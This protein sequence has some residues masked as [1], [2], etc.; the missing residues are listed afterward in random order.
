MRAHR[1]E[2]T[3]RDGDPV[4]NSLLCHQGRRRALLDRNHAQ[5]LLPAGP[6]AAAARGHWVGGGAGEAAVHAADE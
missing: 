2:R 1:H 4:H 5:D 3:H 6:A